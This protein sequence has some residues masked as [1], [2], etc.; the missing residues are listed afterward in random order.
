MVIFMWRRLYPLHFDGLRCIAMAFIVAGTGAGQ[1]AAVVATIIGSIAWLVTGPP[2][3]LS[4]EQYRHSDS[5]GRFLG[6]T[7]RVWTEIAHYGSELVAFLFLVSSF[8]RAFPGKQIVSDGLLFATA[9]IGFGVYTARVAIQQS[10]TT[11]LSNYVL[12]CTFFNLAGFL[13]LSF[14]TLAY[15]IN[16]WFLA[17]QLCVYTYGYYIGTLPLLWSAII[18]LYSGHTPAMVHTPFREQSQVDTAESELI[19]VD[20]NENEGFASDTDDLIPS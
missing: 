11:Q 14:A 6:I 19:S 15:I 2:G 13:A 10:H 17:S 20:L 16:Y 12:A 1:T 7:T 5:N 4:V 3:L 9:A 8:V 18:Q